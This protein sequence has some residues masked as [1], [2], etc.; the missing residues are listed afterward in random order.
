MSQRLL[1]FLGMAV[2]FGIALSVFSP[3]G[4]GGSSVAHVGGDVIESGERCPVHGEIATREHVAEHVAN[5]AG[6]PPRATVAERAEATLDGHLDV[7]EA[8]GGEVGLRW[9]TCEEESRCTAFM[10]VLGVKNVDDDPVR[11]AME[12]QEALPFTLSWTSRHVDGTIV[13]FGDQG[14]AREELREE[15]EARWISRFMEH[16]LSEEEAW[17]KYREGM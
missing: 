14:L 2:A 11:A 4:E 16:G 13:A 5:R 8:L 12:G 3:R 9:V 1:V 17:A 6:V 7:A 10:Q 15:T